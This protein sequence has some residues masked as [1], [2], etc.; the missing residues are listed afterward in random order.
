M[1]Q[2][3]TAYLSID[4]MEQQ[5]LQVVRDASLTSIYEALHTLACRQQAEAT[6]GLKFFKKP[7]SAAYYGD[8]TRELFMTMTK[9]QRLQ[10]QRS[11]EQERH[12]LN[13]ENGIDGAALLTKE[14]VELWKSQGL[15]YAAMARDILGLPQEKVAAITKSHGRQHPIQGRLKKKATD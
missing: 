10:W 7:P 1:A 13:V 6:T 9:E 4:Q 8:M 15:T 5:L 11:K 3:Q 14:N 12:H 2:S